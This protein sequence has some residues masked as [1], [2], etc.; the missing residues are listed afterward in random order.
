MIVKVYRNLTKKCWS[1]QHRGLVIAH[2]NTVE[3]ANVT[4]K[5]SQSGRDRCLREHRKNVHA[6]VVGDLIGCGA[7]PRKDIPLMEVTYDPYK[8]SNFVSVKPLFK[9]REYHLDQYTKY[10]YAFCSEKTVFVGERVHE[11]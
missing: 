11:E 1:I 5:V 10:G 9:G 3:L 4:F 6:F 7:T 8:A 2:A